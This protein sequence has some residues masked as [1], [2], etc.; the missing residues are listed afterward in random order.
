MPG[1]NVTIKYITSTSDHNGLRGDVNG[2]GS[3][4]VTDLSKAAALVKGKKTLS[5]EEAARADVNGDGSVTVSDI[6]RI[7]AHIKGKKSIS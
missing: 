5:A 7:A 4:T 1:K 3:I 6:S 2:D